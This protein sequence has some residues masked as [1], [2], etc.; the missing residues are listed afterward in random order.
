[1]AQPKVESFM[2]WF[3]VNSKLVTAGA[4]VVLIAAGGAWYYQSAKTQKLE[5]ADKQLQLAKQSLRPGNPNTQLAESDLKRVSERYAGTT[6]GTEAGMLLATLKLDKGDAPGAIAYLQELTGKL[7]S[8]PNAAS[9]RSLLGDAY[10]Q[11]GKAAEAAAEYERA[12]AA[13]S[14]PNERAFL[15][16]KA[17]HSYMA[18]GKGPEARRV[19][20]TLASNQESPG[21]AAEARVRLGELLARPAKS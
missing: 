14:M 12:A 16:S 9:A 4:I 11:A 10:S 19:W 17:G 20:E 8:S 13:T 2:D 1:M 3:H 15:L 6:A 18:A 21:L 7:G 5:N